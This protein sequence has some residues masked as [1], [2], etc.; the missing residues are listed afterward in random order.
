[1]IVGAHWD[2]VKDSPGVND[3]GSGMVALLE[4][5]RIVMEYKEKDQMHSV[6]FVAFDKEET[7]CQGSHAFVNNFVVPKLV[8]DFK[9]VIVGIYNL[10]TLLNYS[11]RHG[12]QDIPETW[13]NLDP[14]FAR[15]FEGN[16]RKGDFILTVGRNVEGDT[17]LAGLFQKH[18]KG[19]TSHHLKINE[20]GKVLPEYDLL[21]THIDLWRSDHVRFWYHHQNI[22]SSSA[23]TPFSFN[24]LLIT[25]TAYNRG[26]MKNC[27]HKAALK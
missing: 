8:E 12:S 21:E 6:I 18:L 26:Y 14:D 1:M 5:A 20:F 9:S 7:G 27:Y 24:G 13:R 22:D 15:D 17:K 2:T 25:D 16:G 4:I 23:I 10:D 19:Y 3:N 11:E